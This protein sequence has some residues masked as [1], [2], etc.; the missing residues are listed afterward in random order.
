[1]A[2]VLNIRD[3]FLPGHCRF[4]CTIMHNKSLV[5]VCVCV[6]AERARRERVSLPCLTAGSRGM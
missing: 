6:C 2:P 3:I 1:M 5:R 4:N